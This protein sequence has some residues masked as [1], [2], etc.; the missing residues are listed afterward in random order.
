MKVPYLDLGFQYRAIAPSLEGS[1][2]ELLAS[3]SYVLGKNVEA[4]ESEF[5]E[6]VGVE[7]A[8]G[9]ANGT[10]AVRL[11]L[12]A[13][14]IGPG[15]EVV[16]PLHTFKATIAAIIALGATPVLVDLDLASGHA[17]VDGLCDAVSLKTRAIVVVHMHGYPFPV[18]QLL[19]SLN[20][21]GRTVSVVEDASQAH[22]ALSLARPVGSLGTVAAFSLYPG[23][24]LGAAGD[25]GVVT[26]TSSEIRDRV[27]KLRSWTDLEELDA[28]RGMSWN[29]RLDEVQALILRSKLKLLPAW[30]DSRRE[31][32]ATYRRLLPPDILWPAD[33]N[34]SV[35]HHFVCLVSRRDQIRSALTDA[36][37]ETGVHYATPVS[38]TVLMR[39]SRASQGVEHANDV[40]HR[41]ISLPIGP[42]LEEAQ[43]TYVAECLNRLLT[44][45]VD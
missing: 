6:F 25:A 24:N 31:Q 39:A 40:A 33:P 45:S 28:T 35:F 36:G 43:V 20:R 5:A 26:T 1:L 16:A 38:Q 37:V 9:V 22:G 7:H 44:R 3:G 41:T 18:Q 17:P 14:D 13:L 11:A 32:A 15:D 29:S 23:K 34:G 19:D 30:N 8:I 10:D 4:F 27:L 21:R 42:H 2:E 12:Q